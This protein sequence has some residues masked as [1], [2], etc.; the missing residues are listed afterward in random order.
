MGTRITFKRPDGKEAS[1]YL[2]KAGQRQRAGRRRHPGVVG[3]AGPDQGRLRPLCAGRLRCAGARSLLGR[4][5]A[6]SRPRRGRKRDGL[7]QLPR[8]DR[9]DRAR[10]GAVLKKNGV[11]VGLTGFCMG[12]AVTIIGACKIPELTAGVCFYGIP[13]EAVA[14]PADIKIP[15]QGHFALRDD[16]CTPEAVDKF[17]AGLKAAGKK[18]E[19]YRYDADHGFV[20]EQRPDAHDRAALRTRLGAH[21]GLLAAASGLSVGRVSAHAPRPADF[22]IHETR[23]AACRR[24]A[25]CRAYPPY[26]GIGHARLLDHTETAASAP[27]RPATRA[28]SQPTEAWERMATR[29]VVRRFTD[30]PL[31]PIADRYAVRAGACRRRPRATCSS[32]T[33]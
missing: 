24:V 17:E 12:G 19:L 13:P 23:W 7:A 21:A 15:L 31:P 10:R 6:L 9:A 27:A 26:E 4:R 18:T 8:R 28:A 30:E 3:P 20:N 2:A 33:S 1:G 32:A 25:R 16:W 14:K 5:R 22:S 11:K 29:G